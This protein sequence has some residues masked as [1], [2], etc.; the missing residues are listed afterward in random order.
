MRHN[1]A[2]P[3]SW[4]TMCLVAVFRAQLVSL[5]QCGLSLVELVQTLPV[6]CHVRRGQNIF[7]M[8]WSSESLA[9]SLVACPALHQAL[10]HVTMLCRP[11]TFL[12]HVSGGLA[13]QGLG[14]A[15]PS[16][17]LDPTVPQ[18]TADTLRLQQ[19]P[20]QVCACNRFEES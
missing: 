20:V 10:F 4:H 16:L 12:S 19:V 8:F 6:P 17:V 7:A 14:H 1:W 9:W 15:H 2:G 11:V 3:K 5:A 13:V 18:V